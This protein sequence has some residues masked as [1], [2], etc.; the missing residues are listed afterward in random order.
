MVHTQKEPA[1]RHLSRMDVIQEE[2]VGHR[3]IVKV[4]YGY[5]INHV[6]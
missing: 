1:R 6:F 5:I 4:K 3:K 2:Y